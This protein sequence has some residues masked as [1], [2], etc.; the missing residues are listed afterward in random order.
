M[1]K[2]PEAFFRRFYKV[3]DISKGRTMTMDVS[4]TKVRLIRNISCLFLTDTV[5]QV[6]DLLKRS[7]FD[8]DFTDIEEV[9]NW[10]FDQTN[11]GMIAINGDTDQLILGKHV[12]RDPEP[13]K[14]AI[15]EFYD[16]ISKS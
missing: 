6:N 2:S 3:E 11:I 1:N 13:A 12:Y 4:K 10:I 9:Y 5:E 14:R 16:L 15:A 7:G 8:C